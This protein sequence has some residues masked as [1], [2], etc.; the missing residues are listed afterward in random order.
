MT[1]ETVT[2]RELN[3]LYVHDYNIAST[4]MYVHPFVIEKNTFCFYINWEMDD[5]Q[6]I[7]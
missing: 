1:Y 3:L 5:K 4:S 6:T 2:H 7:Y